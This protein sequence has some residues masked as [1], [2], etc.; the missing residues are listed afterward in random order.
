MSK[1]FGFHSLTRS[2]KTSKSVSLINSIRVSQYVTNKYG[3]K[4]NHKPTILYVT[5]TFDI[6]LSKPVGVPLFIYFFRK[7]R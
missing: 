6:N 5:Q 3:Q 4:W 2:L 1:F 7:L